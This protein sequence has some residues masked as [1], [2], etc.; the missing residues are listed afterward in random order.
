MRS[1]PTKVLWLLVLTSGLLLVACSVADLLPTAT[2]DPANPR[3][4]ATHT[5]V[6]T[7]TAAATPTPDPT[8]TAT[9]PVPS[10]TPSTLEPLGEAYV[11]LQE[12]QIGEYVVRLWRNTASE[13]IGY[14]NIATISGGG[15]PEVRVE[16]AAE[17]GQETG[18]D[19]T[20]EG[21]PDVV[22]EVFTGGA[23]CCLS[24]IVYD[25]G[26]TLTKVLET[27]LSNCGGSFQDLDSDGVAEYVTC[28]DLFAYVY[29]CYAGS[30][31]AQVV[32]RYDPESGYVPASPRYGDT[33]A[34]PIVADTQIAENAE[35]GERC[36]WD[37]TTK[38]GVL[39]LVLDLLYAGQDAQAWAELNRLYPYPD[40]LL[41]WA[42]IVRAVGSSSLYV[43]S[44]AKVDVPYPP[45]Y[46]LY[47][48]AGCGGDMQSVVG[49][50]DGGQPTCEQDGPSRD[51]YW[52]QMQLQDAGLVA[53][54][55]MLMLAPEGCADACRLDVIRIAD[56]AQMGIIRLDVQ[57]G[58]PGEVYRIGETE[59]AH[60]RLRGDLSWERVGQ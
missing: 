10:P 36:E 53:E 21:H 43:P 29:C 5:L 33:Y 15:Q 23:H 52:L 14:D 31:A 40:V 37:E 47:L 18:T 11:I 17:L 42:E 27:P 59:S 57:D 25:L 24:T 38:C 46:M 50:L 48:L 8:H 4:A 20:G 9:V 22:I 16:F 39:P 7:S 26:P 2:P 13:G 44:G 35:P 1:F 32:L 56:N 6:A 28:D 60:W 3:A 55:E 12:R 51:L 41:F 58:F 34:G 54:G 45:Y 30:P 49:V 19:L